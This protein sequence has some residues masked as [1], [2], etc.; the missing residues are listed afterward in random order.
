MK[1]L[2][3]YNKKLLSVYFWFTNL[4]LFLAHADNRND[5]W[6]MRDLCTTIIIHNEHSWGDWWGWQRR[7]FWFTYRCRIF[8]RLVRRWPENVGNGCAATAADQDHGAVAGSAQ[9]TVLDAGPTQ[10]QCGNDQV[11][12]VSGTDLWGHQAVDRGWLPNVF[13]TADPNQGNDGPVAED[14]AK[15][16]RDGWQGR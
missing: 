9:R 2:T 13:G 14:N 4:L 16:K 11:H 8:G 6:R 3:A 15:G 5:H 1:R 12:P 10:G 7:R